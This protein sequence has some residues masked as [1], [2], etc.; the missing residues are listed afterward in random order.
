MKSHWVLTHQVLSEDAGKTLEVP[1][2]TQR[3]DLKMLTSRGAS[4][5]PRLPYGSF[6]SI[7]SH[8]T[9]VLTFSQNGAF[10]GIDPPASLGALDCH[11]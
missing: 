4:T 6:G 10:L 5:Q 3:K 11:G 2:R 7:H 8:C 1:W 9:H